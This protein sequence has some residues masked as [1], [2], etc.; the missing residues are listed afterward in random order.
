MTKLAQLKRA[1]LLNLDVKEVD[2]RIAELREVLSACAHLLNY[3]AEYMNNSPNN[4]LP[5]GIA[6]VLGHEAYRLSKVR[7]KL[8]YGYNVKD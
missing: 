1:D 2:N 7:V 8:A 6:A 3:H 4:T 5:F